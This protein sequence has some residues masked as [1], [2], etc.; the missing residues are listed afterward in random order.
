MKW[1][2]TKIYRDMTRRHNIHSKKFNLP[3]QWKHWIYISGLTKQ[4][5]GYF[6]T[7]FGNLYFSGKGRHF[8]INRFDEFQCSVPI[9]HFD[10]WANSTGYTYPMIPKTEKEFRWVVKTMIEQTRDMK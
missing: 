10:R 8:R 6:R 5:S 1:W 3:K 4:G 2:K 9:E 7:H